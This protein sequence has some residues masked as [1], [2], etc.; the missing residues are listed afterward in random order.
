MLRNAIWFFIFWGIFLVDDHCLQA[1][2]QTSVAA[3]YIEKSMN[4]MQ[5]IANPKISDDAASKLVFDITLRSEKQTA[6]QKVELLGALSDRLSKKKSNNSNETNDTETERANMLSAYFKTFKPTQIV[7]LHS[8]DRTSLPMLHYFV[9][10]SPVISLLLKH[11]ADIAMTNIVNDTPLH[12]AASIGCAQT[13]QLLLE[14]GADVMKKNI[15]N[16]APLHAAVLPVPLVLCIMP[17]QSFKHEKNNVVSMLLDKLKGQHTL[18]EALQSKNN[19]K[20]TPIALAV[21]TALLLSETRS[22]QENAKYID[23]V[24]LLSQ[25]QSKSTKGNAP[26]TEALK[27]VQQLHQHS[28]VDKKVYDQIIKLIQK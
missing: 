22:D 25:A 6:A 18:E 2:Q 8:Q 3:S 20:E 12:T 28:G 26:N 23:C 21:T 9:C 24:R 17:D 15:F 16:Y 27:K 11:D 1:M 10:I 5:V 14:H 7:T 4:L 19:D 13:V